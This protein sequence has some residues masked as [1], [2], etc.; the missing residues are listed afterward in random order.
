MGHVQA[1]FGVTHSL[2][3]ALDTVQFQQVVKLA[4]AGLQREDLG[5]RLCIF[6]S[7]S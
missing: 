6:C 2:H 3:G 4:C 5:T 1:H 7:S